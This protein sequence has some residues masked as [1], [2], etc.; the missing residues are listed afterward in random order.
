MKKSGVIL[1]LLV[2]LVLLIII[3]SIGLVS[4]ESNE[5]ETTNETEAEECTASIRVT[6]NKDVYY[7]G[8]F[9]LQSWRIS[10]PGNRKTRF[11]E[12]NWIRIS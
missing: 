8:D 1:S 5:T 3:S 7:S 4:A 11:G 2:I 6:F 10:L 9:F 12:K